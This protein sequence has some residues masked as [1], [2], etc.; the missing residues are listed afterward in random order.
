M[1]GLY[2]TDNWD[3]SFCGLN[4]AKCKMFESGDCQGCR[5]AD[6]NADNDC[7]PDCELASCAKKR[8]LSYCFECPDFP[9]EKIKKF[10][11][12]RHEHHRL[13]VENLKQMKKVGLKE[14]KKEQ[15]KVVF[16]PGWDTQKT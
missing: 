3:I 15:T 11:T 13:S 9:C 16:C 7:G 8:G 6:K 1:G 12:N 14:W 5:S 4:C 10:A 2:M